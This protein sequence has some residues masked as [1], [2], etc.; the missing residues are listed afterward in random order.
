MVHIIDK[1]PSSLIRTYFNGFGSK[2]KN[3]SNKGQT[4]IQ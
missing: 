3:E 2:S 4:F 1:P